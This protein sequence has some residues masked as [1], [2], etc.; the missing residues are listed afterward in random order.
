M[1]AALSMELPDAE[2]LYQLFRSAMK[3]HVETA[4]GAPWNDERERAQF[5]AQL[6]AE[7]VQMIVLEGE[8]VG[9]V[10]I[11]TGDDGCFLHTMVIAPKWQSGGIGGAVLEELKAKSGRIALTV[12]K[13]NRRARRFYEKAGFREVGST[14]HHCRM[15]WTANPTM[16]GNE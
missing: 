6:A 13:T 11:R 16:A 3:K 8:A 15:T 7:S 4:R 10:D 2:E 12:L 5:L 9:F 14:E 1:K